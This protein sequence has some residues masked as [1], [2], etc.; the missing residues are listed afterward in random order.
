MKVLVCGG[1][2][3]SDWQRVCELLDKLHA[4]HVIT[5]V[6][7]GG[8]AGADDLAGRWAYERG[9]QEVICPANWNR[10]GLTA[11]PVRNAAMLELRPDLVVA[12]P[13]GAG[14]NSTIQLALS[15]RVAV[16]R[17]E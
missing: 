8:A 17:E 1:R 16:H 4:E 3:Y 10:F 14:T 7:H 12:F 6:L 13:G 5:H 15:A 9:A 2:K 11:G